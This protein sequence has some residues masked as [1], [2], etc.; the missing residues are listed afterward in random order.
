MILQIG[1]IFPK[2]RKRR[3]R[4]LTWRGWR[5]RRQLC[6]LALLAAASFDALRLSGA[7][8]A[9]RPR[10]GRRSRSVLAALDLL[11]AYGDRGLLVAAGRGQPGEGAE[12][13]GRAPVCRGAVVREF[14]RL[15]KKSLRFRLIVLIYINIG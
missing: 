6:R 9:W 7:L 11:R 1:R 15:G 10:S 14:A 2:W 4:P 3:A 13:A 12:I 5:C 8:S